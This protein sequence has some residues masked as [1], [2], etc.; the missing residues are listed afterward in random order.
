MSLR[1]AR[2]GERFRPTSRIGS[3]NGR[4]AVSV[5][6]VAQAVRYARAHRM[7]IAPQGIIRVRWRS[8]AVVP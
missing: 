8:W 7:R 2:P 1:T 5:A 4:R 6:D 3:V